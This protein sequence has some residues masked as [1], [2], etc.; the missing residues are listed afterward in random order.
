MNMLKR[1]HRISRLTNKNLPVLVGFSDFVSAAHLR[2]RHATHDEDDETRS[3]RLVAHA[4]VA[5]TMPVA[6]TR[7]PTIQISHQR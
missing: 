7:R 4:L 2:E 1:L 5:V 3:A 6:I